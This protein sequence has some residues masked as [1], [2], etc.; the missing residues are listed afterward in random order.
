MML[1]L[2]DMRKPP[3]GYELWAKSYDQCVKLLLKHGDDIEHV[4]LDHDLSEEHYA[5]ASTEYTEGQPIDRSAFKEKTGYDI[6]SWMHE[7]NHWVPDISIHTMNPK[8][9]QD[10]MTKLQNRAPAHVK[11]RRVHLSQ[12]V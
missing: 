4:S 9:A 11:F 3:W 12:M 8:G 2:D 1:W 6:L 5:T 10:M 7:H